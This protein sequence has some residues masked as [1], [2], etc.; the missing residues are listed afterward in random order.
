MNLFNTVDAKCEPFR[1]RSR[2]A[3]GIA[4]GLAPQTQHIKIMSATIARAE[5]SN[6]IVTNF[7]DLKH[8]IDISIL[9]I[10]VAGGGGG[11]FPAH[12]SDAVAAAVQQGPVRKADANRGGRGHGIVCIRNESGR[13]AG[14][15]AERGHRGE[16]QE[17]EL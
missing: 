11:A 12:I 4:R 6:Y 10:P 15:N 2:H 7:E 5:T 9:I 13:N 17:V 16:N 3:F 1:I 8:L 14:E